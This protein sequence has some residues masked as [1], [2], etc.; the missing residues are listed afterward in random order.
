[1]ALSSVRRAVVFAAHPDD[2]VIGCGGTIRRLATE[3][4]T[5]TVV[6]ATTGDT[7]I[8]PRFIAVPD[9]PGARR[10]ESTRSK[11]LLGVDDVI[12]LEHRTQA[13]VNDRATFQE[14]VR[15]IRSFRPELVLCHGPDDKHRDHRVVS[16]LTREAVWK[17]WENV[18]PDLGPRHRVAEA[19]MYEITDPFAIPDVVVDISLTL[20]AKLAALNEHVTQG[21]VLGDISDFVRG[22]ASVRGYAI[23]TRSGEAFRSIGVLP[24]A[25]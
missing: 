18:M 20:D 5:V 23:G 19:W 9:L 10:A 17:A 8:S 24:R 3:G 1:M 14:W 22:L 15:V 12:F 6:I 13:L 21:E 4:A 11:D 25:F 16:A 2:E 7:G